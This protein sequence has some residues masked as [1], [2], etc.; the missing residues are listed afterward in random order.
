MFPWKFKIVKWAPYTQ[1]NIELL[2]IPQA[3]NLQEKT[4]SCIAKMNESDS[5]TVISHSVSVLVYWSNI[6][7]FLDRSWHIL[8]SYEGISLC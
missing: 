4:T 3:K 6:S 8:S 2:W 1:V 5:K 7:L